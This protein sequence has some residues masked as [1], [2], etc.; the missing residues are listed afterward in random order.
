RAAMI[1]AIC[2]R[3]DGI[4]LAI[5]LAAARAA[6]LGV[7]E[8][9]THLDDRF[10]ILTGGRR[11]ALPRHQTL[12]A[13]LDWSYELLSEPERLLLRRLAIFAGASALDAVRAIVA[14]PEL[15]ASAV[16]DGIASLVVKSL[17]QT[18]VGAIA[19]YRLLDTTRAYALEKLAESGEREQLARRHAEYYRAVF[20]QAETELE[21]GLRAE[22]PA[23]YRS[24]IDNLR[25]A[26]DW[27]FSP[28]GDASVGVTL[29]AAAVPFWT[30]L[31]LL[32]EC[33]GWVEQALATLGAG[34]ACGAHCEMKLHAALGASLIYTSTI[35][36]EI[37]AAWTKA[38]EIAESLDDAGYQ[39][40]ALVGLFAVHLNSGQCRTALALAERFH[41]LAATRPDPTDRLTAERLIGASQHLLGNQ[42]AAQRHF[43]RILADDTLDRRSYII[44]YQI[45]L[46]VLA[47][48][49]RSWTLWLRGF[50]DQAMR[51]AG[52]SVED[53]HAIDHTLSLC[54]ALARAACP[55]A[56]LVGDLAAAE[57]YIEMLL[58]HSTKH[59]V[60]HWHAIGRC[61]QGVLAIR[62][63]DVT[64]GSRLLHA[65][66]G[67]LGDKN[68]VILR[69][70]A[71]L[72]AE[73]LSRAGQIGDGL[74]AVE[75]T[76][77]WT[78][79]SE[80][81]WLIADL[82]RIKGELL[83]LQGGSGIQTADDLFRRALDCARRQGALSWELRA[84][85]SLARLRREEG[86]AADASAVLE[87]VYNRFTEGFE[88]VDLVEA[89]G[90]LAELNDAAA[91][92]PSA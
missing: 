11:T 9:A 69:L 66:L 18:G 55:I 12:R 79:P 42:L 61:Q 73:A 84:A 34:A 27:A 3:L 24:R 57:L 13:T 56:L 52:S 75:E 59:G 62:R 87:P 17:V 33:R 67:D 25:A 82:Q 81:H 80:E 21:T 6:V 78:E 58:D 85:T 63:G 90:L 10:R 23:D 70:V 47:H 8:V 32:D 26:L 37:A 92:E 30:Q 51:T 68:S 43:E 14:G 2:R 36:P 83:R 4:P 40:R 41:A 15:S 53:A 65:G 50:P 44:R 71:F 22:R 77:A 45:D 74:A 38:L 29:T 54:Y 7:E 1:A 16:V 49:F 86:R 19:R 91:T 35:V 64:L 60:A 28:G 88:S 5:E 31:S 48:V 72:M 46:R 20:E 39:L 89:R 76:L